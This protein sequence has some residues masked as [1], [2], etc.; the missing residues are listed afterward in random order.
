M[1]L[2]YTQSLTQTNILYDIAQW[3]FAT[4]KKPCPDMCDSRWLGSD[5][6]MKGRRVA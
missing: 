6:Q 2:P 3:K 5:N 1:W 4:I